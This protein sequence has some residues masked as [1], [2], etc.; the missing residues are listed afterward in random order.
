[1]SADL[2]QNGEFDEGVR[3][4]SAPLEILLRKFNGLRRPLS[5]VL[6][7]P[8]ILAEFALLHL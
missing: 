5:L 4:T 8:L 6:E 1:V 2:L 3:E 7:H